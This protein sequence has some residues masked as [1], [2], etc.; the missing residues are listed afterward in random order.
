MIITIISCI[1]DYEN[2]TFD[3]KAEV[4]FSI[5][6]NF[7]ELTE[8]LNKLRDVEKMPDYIKNDWYKYNGIPLT[9][10]TLDKHIDKSD[11]RLISEQ[12][13]GGFNTNDIE[14]ERKNLIYLKSIKRNFRID[15]IL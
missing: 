4:I 13:R 6:D 10:N 12:T 14:N 3:S 9:E 1:E 11:K 7:Y 8:D 15:S 5:D 2:Y